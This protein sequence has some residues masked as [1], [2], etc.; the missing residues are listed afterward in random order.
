MA[1]RPPIQSFRDLKVWQ[2][3]L[4]LAEAT[5]GFTKRFPSEERYGL[6]IQ[7]RRA[8]TSVPAS[9]AEGHDRDSTKE[10]LRFLSIGVGS[11]AE[12]ETCM[13]L[14]KRLG[15]GDP[16]AADELF[17]TILEERKML[18]GLQRSLKNKLPS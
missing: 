4:D 11:L 6:T 18:R 5:Y 12:V 14:S 17:N 3:G 2:V 13:E 1:Q 8:S 10:F 7:M 16:R 9:I 15:F